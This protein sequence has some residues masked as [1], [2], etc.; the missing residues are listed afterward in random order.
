MRILYGLTLLP[1][2]V[3]MGALTDIKKV[4]GEPGT[5][6]ARATSD[7]EAQFIP[8]T[9][10]P[11]GTLKRPKGGSVYYNRLGNVSLVEV[12]FIGVSDGTNLFGARTCYIDIYLL[13]KDEK[14]TVQQR[15]CNVTKE[16]PIASNAI[17]VTI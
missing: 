16:N 13:P 5:L 12:L 1:I 9:V 17:E 10:G 8:Q 6:V 2:L 11:S 3:F 4:N 14:R 15:V 7:E